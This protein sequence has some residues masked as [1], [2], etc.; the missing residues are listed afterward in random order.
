MALRCAVAAHHHNKFLMLLTM[1]G[2]PL[3]TDARCELIGNPPIR[4]RSS[5]SYIQASP[6]PISISILLGKERFSQATAPSFGKKILSQQASISKGQKHRFTFPAVFCSPVQHCLP[7]EPPL[8]EQSAGPMP[9]KIL[10]RVPDHLVAVKCGPGLVIV[11]HGPISSEVLE[12]PASVARG[13]P[14]ST[15]TR[16]PAAVVFAASAP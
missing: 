13:S 12:G 16:S 8:W 2:E 9:G 15:W 5:H 6:P 11:H 7:G 14:A 4:Y 3:V 1:L 10:F